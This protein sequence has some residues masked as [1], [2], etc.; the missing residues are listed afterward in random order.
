MDATTAERWR[1]WQRER[2]GWT[3]S[4]NLLRGN[5]R[6]LTRDTCQPAHA[7]VRCRGAPHGGPMTRQIAVLMLLLAVALPSI[8]GAQ[9]PTTDYRVLATSKTSTMQ[10]EMQ[11]A[12]DAGYRFVAVMGGETAFGGNE[13]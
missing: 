1:R 8:A 4:R 6:H 3:W 12:A 11:A 5:V 9:R 10:K 7:R 13:V 2:S